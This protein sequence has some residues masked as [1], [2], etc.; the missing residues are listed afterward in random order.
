DVSTLGE[1]RFALEAGVPVERIVFHGNNKSDEELEAAAA[2]HITAVLDAPDEAERAIRAGIERVIVRLTPGVEAETHE[3][4]QTAHSESKFGLDPDQA[5]AAIAAARERADVGGVHAHIG[6]QLVRADESLTAV[7]R[8]AEFCARCRD[9]LEWQPRVVDLG[10]G[11]GVRH[12]RD[13][14]IPSI[15]AFAGALV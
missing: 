8:V 7:D 9:E 3:S 12:S 1:L 4:I 14:Q 5:R 2:A 11:L 15:G 13:E 10:G 6:S